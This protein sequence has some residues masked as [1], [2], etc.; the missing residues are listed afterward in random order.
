MS[1]TALIGDE[2]GRDEIG[3]LHRASEYRERGAAL[4]QRIFGG[5]SQP[6]DLILHHQFSALQ[7]DYLQVVR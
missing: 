3:I 6:L 1:A 2:I 4:V 7:F 5:V